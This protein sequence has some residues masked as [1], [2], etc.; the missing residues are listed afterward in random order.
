MGEKGLKDYDVGEVFVGF[1]VIRKS[2]LKHKKN[3]EPYL[4]LELGDR[5]G[6]LRGKMW[7]GG[8]EHYDNL[9]IGQLIKVKGKIQSYLDNKELHIE[10][11]RPA[12]KDEEAKLQ[13]IV[14]TSKKDISALR[15][16]FLSQ[17]ST[18]ENVHLK[19]L[20]ETVFP[21]S[22]KWEE[23]LKTPSGKLWHHNYLYGTL[24][25]LL[26]LLELT[27]AIIKHYPQIDVDLLKSGI[28]L[29]NI[30]TRIEYNY[31]DF[32]D[33]S[34]D[35]RL[36]GKSVVGYDK[37]NETID[38]IE[39]FPHELKLQLQHFILSQHGTP[40][41]GSSVKPMTLEAIVLQ[42]LNELDVQTNAT[43]RI[44]ENDRI[45]ESDWTKYNNLLD[46]FVYVGNK[47]KDD[48][49]HKKNH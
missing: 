7:Q 34:T 3:G 48:E 28:I 2:E 12:R 42:H 44:I 4:M 37:L 38:E 22:E 13:E 35:G 41:K 8:L 16:K 19:Q 31:Q 36:L 15:E 29:K 40:E 14:P 27:D 9:R 20:L 46:R 6:R 1:C 25:H 33:Y 39:D 5:S 43:V 11:L 17:L 49:S 18:I 45:P 30:G 26:C 24:E 10:K 47:S 32:I 21:D 23:Y